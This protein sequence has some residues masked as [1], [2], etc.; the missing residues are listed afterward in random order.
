MLDQEDSSS[1]L[2]S[3]AS[4]DNVL[5]SKSQLNI[6]YVYREVTSEVYVNRMVQAYDIGAVDYVEDMVVRCDASDFD[7]FKK[8][9]IDK[10]CD[11]KYRK[12]YEKMFMK[13]LDYQK[14]NDMSKLRA[15]GDAPHTDYKNSK[16]YY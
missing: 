12:S 15:T 14:E 2:K 7:Y 4:S 3:L 16:I 6:F 11:P 8:H 13:L 10:S 5:Y 1:I 9:Y